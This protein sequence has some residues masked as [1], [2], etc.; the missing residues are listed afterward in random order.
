MGD[1]RR[2]NSR[3]GAGVET[4]ARSLPSHGRNGTRL[5]AA[6]DRGNLGAAADGNRLGSGEK[7]KPKKADTAGEYENGGVW[8]ITCFLG[9]RK[10]GKSSRMGRLLQAVTRLVLFDGRGASPLSQNFFSKF[11]F[12]HTFTQ[13][14]QLRAFLRAHLG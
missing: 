2:R 3:S 1:R 6:G 5:R 10:S 7:R 12:D 14:G 11:G 4:R 13:P 9:K 8:G